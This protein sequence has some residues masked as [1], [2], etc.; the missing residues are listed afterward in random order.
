MNDFRIIM[1]C[2]ITPH[3][4]VNRC[5]LFS[6]LSYFSHSFLKS[7]I[8]TNK[9]LLMRLRVKNCP[10]SSATVIFAC[11]SRRG[12]QMQIQIPLGKTWPSECHL[13]ITCLFNKAS[14]QCHVVLFSIE[15][16]QQKVTGQR[17]F[18]FL[19]AATKL[20]MFHSVITLEW[21]RWLL[22]RLDVSDMKYWSNHVS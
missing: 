4:T 3:L 14:C 10:V 6:Q 13:S 22:H 15:L 16:K 21:N 11:D 20:N 7:L 2:W 5:P 17:F 18:F 12:R 8:Y 19:S 1:Q 9:C